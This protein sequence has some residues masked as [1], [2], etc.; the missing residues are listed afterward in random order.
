MALLHGMELYEHHYW[1]E[2][3]EVWEGLWRTQ[4]G[5]ARDLTQT[6]ILQAAV[7]LLHHLGRPEAAQRAAARAATLAAQ[8]G[9][10]LEA[11][12]TEHNFTPTFRET[13]ASLTGQEHSPD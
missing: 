4:T 11:L 3:H 13:D 9:P 2:A 1:W 5:A 6:L 10:Q 12:R 7:H 8:L